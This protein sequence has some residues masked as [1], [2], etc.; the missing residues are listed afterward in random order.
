MRKISSAI[1]AIAGI[2]AILT[3]CSDANGYPELQG[4]G[5]HGPDGYGFVTPEGKFIEC[6]DLEDVPSPL[7]N[8][9]FCTNG[10]AIPDG[11]WHQTDKPVTLCRLSGH[12]AVTVRDNLVDCGYCGYGLTPTVRADE[13]IVMVDCDGNPRLVLDMYDGKYISDLDR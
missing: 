9:M 4:L 2:S 3:S 1:F 12:K 8:G 13:P 5:G 7:V 10:F 6:E 11:Q